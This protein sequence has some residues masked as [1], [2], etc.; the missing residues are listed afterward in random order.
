M[1]VRFREKDVLG[2]NHRYVC[3][4]FNF[5]VLARLTFTLQLCTI[6]PYLYQSK[7]ACTHTCIDKRRP[8]EWHLHLQAEC[9]SM[10]CLRPHLY[11]SGLCSNCHGLQVVVSSFT[12]WRLKLFWTL[13]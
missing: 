13:L 9:V 8:V 1:R 3:G 10:S 12:Q 5:D 4:F 7:V 2:A 11:M 6:Q